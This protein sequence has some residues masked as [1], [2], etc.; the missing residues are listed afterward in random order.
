MKKTISK[1][2]TGRRAATGAK[3][4]AGVASHYRTSPLARKMSVEK[5]MT[6]ESLISEQM[7]S[8][9]PDR[10]K[11]VVEVMRDMRN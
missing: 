9:K 6:E 7:R 11:P 1:S 2:P 4:S 5:W 8:G 3:K 10:S